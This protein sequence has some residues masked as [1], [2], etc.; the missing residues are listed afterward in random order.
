MLVNNTSEKMLNIFKHFTLLCVTLMAS[1]SAQGPYW[2][3]DTGATNSLPANN[4]AVANVGQA[5]WMALKAFE[6]FQLLQ[7]GAASSVHTELFIS[8][9]NPNG[10]FYPG[11]PDPLPPTWNADQLAPLQLGSLKALA[12]PFYYQLNLTHSNWVENQLKSS[13][14]PIGGIAVLGVDYFQ[15]GSGHYYPWNPANNT[16]SQFNLAPATI[17]QLKAV[18]SLDFLSQDL[19]VN[20]EGDYDLDG[21]SNYQE[22]LRGTNPQNEDTDGDGIDDYK[23]TE[24]GL[25][26]VAYN[27]STDWE[28]LSAKPIVRRASSGFRYSFTETINSFGY[29]DQ[30]GF[31]DINAVSAPDWSWPRAELI[32]PEILYDLEYDLLSDSFPNQSNMA[33]KKYGKNKWPNFYPHAETRIGLFEEDEDPPS[34]Y[35]LDDW[36]TIHN[37]YMVEVPLPTSFDRSFKALIIPFKTVQKHLRVYWNPPAPGA[38]SPGPGQTQEEADAEALEAYRWEVYGITEENTILTSGVEPLD[39]LVLANETNSQIEE[40][41]PWIGGSVDDHYVRIEELVVA[42][43]VVEVHPKLVHEDGFELDWTTKPNPIWLTTEMVERAPFADP[44]IED[45]SAVRIAWRDLKVKL[46]PRLAGKTITWSM[47][48]LFIKKATVEDPGPHQPMFKGLWGKAANPN[49]RHMFSA[50]EK[51]G[52]HDYELGQVAINGEAGKATAS[53]TVDE[54]GY[55]A[56]RVNMPPIGFNKARVKVKIGAIEEE[57]HLIDLEVPA[58]IVIDPGHGSGPNLPG[59][60]SIGGTADDSGE[61]EYKFAYDL[62]LETRLEIRNHEENDKGHIKVFLT[63]ENATNIPAVSRTKVARDQG[64]DV[65]MSIHFNDWDDRLHRDPFGMWDDTGNINTAED[66]ALAVSLRKSV[67]V[68]IAAIEPLA[69]RNSPRSSYDSANWE[70]TSQKGLDTCSDLQAGLPY[71]GNVSGYTPCRAALIEVEWMS[72]AAADALFNVAPLMGPMRSRTAKEL[73]DGCIQDALIQTSV[74]TIDIP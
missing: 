58:V 27:Y 55:T 40:I 10:V 60:S 32:I 5:K 8:P 38:T 30:W 12:Q 47:E 50:S 21:L 7:P 63:R 56:I 29:D 69:S 31:I 74:N 65:Y 13:L 17:G 66:S 11:I 34:Y 1:A 36:K 57:L 22:A 62:A 6:S 67:Q 20:P 14:K 45:A 33:D 35:H 2:W 51:Y 54:G 53:T 23:E 64:C 16:N 73:A 68:A 25:D 19:M 39:F 26:P 28:V 46:S 4:S 3:Y 24:F 18:F 61:P 44:K 9:T 41:T 49:Y 43:D 37:S 72:H 48:P 42:P 59:S 15:D 71:N 52:L 70:T